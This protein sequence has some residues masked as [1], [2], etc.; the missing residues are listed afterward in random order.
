MLQKA[1][2]G[3]TSTGVALRLY[4]CNGLWLSCKSCHAVTRHG[5]VMCDITIDSV[6]DNTHSLSSGD[7]LWHWNFLLIVLINEYP[8]HI[9]IA[10]LLG[11]SLTLS[12]MISSCLKLLYC[13]H[14][15]SL[16]CKNPRKCLPLVLRILYTDSNPTTEKHSCVFK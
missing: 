14:C 9:S 13:I 2:K 5:D 8:C 12:I 3:M 6:G 15:S 7:Q 1:S 10:L 11:D 16:P 4:L